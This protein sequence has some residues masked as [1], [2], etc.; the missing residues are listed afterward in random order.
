MGR[1]IIP[2]IDRLMR[3]VVADGTC[4]RATKGIRKDGY[5]QVQLTGKRAPK[6]LGHRLS[7]EHF[8]GPVPDGL[9]LDHV[10]ANGCRFRS[11][12]N[13]AHLEPVTRS[14]NILR[15]TAPEQTTAYYDAY[16]ANRTHCDNGHE[17]AK[18]GIQVESGTGFRSCR[19]CHLQQKRENH[20]RAMADPVKAARVR[21]QNRRA[22][23]KYR[24]K[25]GA[26]A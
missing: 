11:C 12:V 20:Q 25:K 14:V 17:L 21:E 15:G 3:W 9:E 26:A 19:A 16:W 7:Y 24:A 2:P 13:P 4:W 18:V 8:V 22:V 10:W 23:A 5:C 1:K 6:V